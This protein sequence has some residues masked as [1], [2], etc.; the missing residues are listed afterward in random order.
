MFVS[1]F[2]VFAIAEFSLYS[3]KLVTRVIS[4]L[5]SLGSVHPLKPHGTS[6][7]RSS[8]ILVDHYI[9][10]VLYGYLWKVPADV[11]HVARTTVLI[12]VFTANAV[13]TPLPVSLFCAQVRRRRS[14]SLVSETARSSCGHLANVT[15]ISWWISTNPEVVRTPGECDLDKLVDIDESVQQAMAIINRNVDVFGTASGG[16]RVPPLVFARL[17][18]GGKSTF[19]ACLFDELK[20]AGMAPILISFNGMFKRRMGES[21]LSA[22]ARQLSEQFMPPLPEGAEPLNYDP[23]EVVAHINDTCD[24]RKVILLIDELN[25]LA[26]GPLDADSACFLKE[27]FLDKAGR[28]LVFTSHAPLDIDTTCPEDAMSRYWTSPMS[29]RG[30]LTVHQPL[31]VDLALLRQMPGCAALTSAEVAIYGGIPSLIYAAKGHAELTPGGRFLKQRIELTKAEQRA[32]LGAFITEVLSG[33]RRPTGYS[34]FYRFASTPGYEAVWWPLC[35]I[36]CILGLFQ[37]LRRIPFAELVEVHLAAHASRVD[38]G[39][40]WE[41]IVQAALMLQCMD[42]MVNGGRGPFDIAEPDAHPRFEFHTFV[43][44]VKSLEQARTVITS[45]LGKATRPTLML[46][47]SAC[48]KF[49]AYDGFIGY[50]GTDGGTRVFAHQEKLGRAY[51][52]QEIQTE[53]WIERSF[54]VRGHA[55]AAASKCKGWEYLDRDAILQLLGSSLAPLYPAAWPQPP[56]VDS[57]DG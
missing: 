42:A 18:R 52:T 57:S 29:P 4:F 21:Q 46:F 14:W 11:T 13:V 45:R 25:A 26:G 35:Y 41:L 39:V 10:S 48:V 30:F 56:E 17:A 53:G 28:Y 7:R 22:L 54:H 50:R 3:Y 32:V 40:D 15:S 2:S 33:K 1:L 37:E 9:Y 55:P 49:P 27:E 34:P 31:S 16:T 38:S 51:P 12:Y 44:E 19:L 47:S 5:S 24:G 20:K 23:R 36:Q 43:G 8:P 6:D